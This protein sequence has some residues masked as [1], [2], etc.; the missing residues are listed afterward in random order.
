M[1]RKDEVDARVGT[2]HVVTVHLDDVADPPELA[3]GSELHARDA[4]ANDLAR[5]ELD[6]LLRAYLRDVDQPRVEMVLYVVDGSEACRHARATLLDVVRRYESRDVATVIR[7]LSREPRTPEDDPLIL[8]PTLVVKHPRALMMA[9][10][11]DRPALDD[12]LVRAG[13][14]PRAT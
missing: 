9:G 1:G 2:P 4:L 11:I 3:L 10:E 6:A 13:A 7:N 12:L 14:R 8:V 5:E